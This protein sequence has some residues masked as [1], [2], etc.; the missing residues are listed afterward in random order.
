[1]LSTLVG[2]GLGLAGVSW[3]LVWRRE[4]R[5]NLCPTH[6]RVGP[7][8]VRHDV[9]VDCRIAVEVARTVRIIWPFL[10]D[11]FPNQSEE[12]VL[13]VV[14]DPKDRRPGRRRGRRVVINLASHD[15][16]DDLLDT[17]AEELHHLCCPLR[18]DATMAQV[19]WRLLRQTFRPEGIR[20]WKDI[21][22]YYALN[23]REYEA[24][25]FA[26]ALVGK[27]VRLLDEV[28]EYRALHGIK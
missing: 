15:S 17:I 24:L 16:G 6:H 19:L 1:M 5:T 7:I 20:T 27:R 18:R 13:H 14:L 22:R 4:S 28:E 11:Q 12:L 8:T 9:A 3:S 23:P 26:V 21:V 25:R 10:E 2:L